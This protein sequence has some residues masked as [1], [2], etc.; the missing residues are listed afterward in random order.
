M[1]RLYAALLASLMAV[2]CL[3]LVAAPTQA[4]TEA[5]KPER[6]LSERPPG[7]HQIDFHSF[8][9]KGR[10]EEPQAD[11]TLLPYA[12]RKVV[13]QKRSCKGC[14]WK[15]AKVLKTNDRGVYLSRILAPRTGRWYWRV[16]IKA[17][18]GYATTTGV[19]WGTGN[20]RTG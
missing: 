2:S 12:D 3:A 6:V 5:A 13:L 4:I 8:A 11:G 15:S 20:Q 14:A 7:E 18:N 9:L 1:A 16:R 17:S 10:V 19:V